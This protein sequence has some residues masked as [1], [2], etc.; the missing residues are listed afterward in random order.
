MGP[1]EPDRVTSMPEPRVP[2]PV[3]RAQPQAVDASR[4]PWRPTRV[5]VAIGA[6]CVVLGGLVAAVTEPLKLADGSWLAAYLVLVC[7]VAPYAM[8]HAPA[9]LAG[10]EPTAFLGW[11]GLLCWNLG[12]AGVIAGTLTATPLLVDAGAPSLVAGLVIAW[13]AARR[14][15]G[16][17]GRP[18]LRTLG[19]TYRILLLVLAVSILVGVALAYLGSAT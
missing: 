16:A 5:L 12:N 13:L 19:W 17:T 11:A 10:R 18:W 2:A 6:G 8:G 7:G 14:T 1:A 15:S 9:H 3:T 4:G